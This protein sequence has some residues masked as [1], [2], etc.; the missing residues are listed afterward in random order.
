MKH[1]GGYFS[2]EYTDRNDLKYAVRGNFTSLPAENEV[3]KTKK[4]LI[5]ISYHKTEEAGPFINPPQ[6][7]ELHMRQTEIAWEIGQYQNEQFKFLPSH[8]NLWLKDIVLAAYFE[9]EEKSKVL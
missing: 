5:F 3:N 6:S 4:N 9:L 7:A 1:L 2:S 8:F